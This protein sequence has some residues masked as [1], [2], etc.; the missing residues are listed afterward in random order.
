MTYSVKSIYP[1]FKCL[2]AHR[3]IMKRIETAQKKEEKTN[4][5]FKY[6]I[7]K[8]YK[9]VGDEGFN[10]KKIYMKEF[11]KD[12][13]VED[14]FYFKSKEFSRKCGK[15]GN[16]HQMWIEENHRLKKANPWF[17]NR[18]M[19]DP[20]HCEVYGGTYGIRNKTK[21]DKFFYWKLKKMDEIEKRVAF[22]DAML[23]RDYKA[24]TLC[25]DVIGLIYEYL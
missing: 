21:E 1:E 10:N 18:N 3:A 4:K 23:S 7:I 15:I 24:V 11:E 25:D 8:N 13:E 6:I 9:M 19:Y 2:T 20:K 12:L 14:I 22:Y 5:A 17:Y 16:N